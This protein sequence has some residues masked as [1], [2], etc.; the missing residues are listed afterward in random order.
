MDVETLLAGAEGDLDRELLTASGDGGPL[1]PGYLAD[2]PAVDALAPGEQPHYLLHNNGRKAVVVTAPD[3]R[4]TRI[5][6]AG[7]YRTMTLVTDRR[8]LVLVGGADGDRELAFAYGDLRRA[9][10]DEGFVVD[11]LRLEERDATEY[12]VPVS[13]GPDAAADYADERISAAA[14]A[15]AESEDDDEPDNP[16]VGWDGDGGEGTEDRGDGGHDPLA[17]DPGDPT[18]GQ[19]S[20]SELGWGDGIERTDGAG[21]AAARPPEAPPGDGSDP[22]ADASANDGGGGLGTD[23]DGGLPLGDLP[24]PGDDAAA[25]EASSPIPDPTPSPGDDDGSTSD[26]TAPGDGGAVDPA[27]PARLSRV[28]LRS[29]L[30]GMDAY[31]FEHLLADVWSALGWSTT[32]TDGSKDKGIDVV[33]RKDKPFQQKHL[34]QAK[35]YGADN[36]VGAREVQL[37]ASLRQQ[38]QNVD[39][40][41][42]VTTSTFT[43][44]AEARAADL[45]V[46]LVDLDDLCDL[47]VAEDCASVVRSYWEPP[48]ERGREQG[49]DRTTQT[50]AN[51]RRDGADGSRDRDDDAEDGRARRGVDADPAI[52]DLAWGRDLE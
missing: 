23:A 9:T 36:T 17:P 25:G 46:K 3:G 48:A 13:K 7:D 6:G 50:R 42:I 33:A 35:R 28:Q 15:A 26:P 43:A 40:V 47:I 30:R 1:T 8:V 12:S 41:V 4:T 49:E 2:G 39:S 51:G 16:W 52:D 5:D 29:L 18:D 44:D 22:L 32:V 45:N 11:R 27:A 21:D 37:Y 14:V 31:A 24:T 20:L 34:L 10:V 19:V 38:E